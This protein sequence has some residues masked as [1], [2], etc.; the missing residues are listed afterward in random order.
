MHFQQQVVPP[1]MM[2]L[3]QTAVPAAALSSSGSPATAGSSDSDKWVALQGMLKEKQAARAAARAGVYPF[4]FLC[5]Y[6]YIYTDTLY[7][8]I[9]LRILIRYFLLFFFFCRGRAGQW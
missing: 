5:T 6:K 9:H 2:T 3:A 1:P 7:I 8:Q 4:A